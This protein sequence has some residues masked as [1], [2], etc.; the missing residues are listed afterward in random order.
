MARVVSHVTHLYPAHNEYISVFGTIYVEAHTPTGW[1]SRRAR[2]RACEILS[3]MA[4]MGMSARP[5][6]RPHVLV[7]M[8]IR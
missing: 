1:A 3:E 4:K 2:P 7:T 6:D 8:A 5:T